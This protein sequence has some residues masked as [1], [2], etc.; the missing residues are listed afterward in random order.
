MLSLYQRFF[1]VFHNITSLIIC[2]YIER[3]AERK[4][5]RFKEFMFTVRI[6]ILWLERQDLNLRPLPPQEI[7]LSFFSRFCFF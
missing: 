3:V 1:C 2:S 6:D 5:K 4:I 7:E